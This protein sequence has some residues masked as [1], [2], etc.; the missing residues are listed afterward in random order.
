MKLL[1]SDVRGK[2]G[3]RTVES[4]NKGGSVAEWLRR[5]T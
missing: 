1:S 3:I 5:Q 4:V 2:E